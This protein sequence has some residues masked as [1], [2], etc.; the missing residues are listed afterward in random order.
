MSRLPGL[1]F[2][3]LLFPALICSTSAQLSAQAVS[4]TILG[5]VHD[6]SG[7]LVANAPITITNTATGL[8]R[9]VETDASGEFSAPSLPPGIYSLTVQTEAFKKTCTVLVPPTRS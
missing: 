2:D 5:T 7:A 9:T 8:H 1:R 6:A 3:A 4:G